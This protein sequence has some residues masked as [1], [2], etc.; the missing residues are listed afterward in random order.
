VAKGLA[1]YPDKEYQSEW[2]AQKLVEAKEIEKDPKRHKAAIAKA[3][4][5]AAEKLQQAQFMRAIAKRKA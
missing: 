5:L 1:S 2:D 3:K 4:K